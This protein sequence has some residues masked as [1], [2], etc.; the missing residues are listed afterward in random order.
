MTET[1]LKM[2]FLTLVTALSLLRSVMSVSDCDMLVDQFTSN[3]SLLEAVDS[4]NIHNRHDLAANNSDPVLEI[5]GSFL[6]SNL[7][8]S[9]IVCTLSN[10]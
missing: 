1:K 2:R 8:F 4:M 10:Y 7:H 6:T 3:S 9:N 5:L